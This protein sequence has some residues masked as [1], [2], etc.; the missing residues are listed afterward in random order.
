MMSMKSGWI[1]LYRKMMEHW[2]W[3]YREPYDRRSA[4]QY[5]LLEAYFCDSTVFHKGEIIHVERGQFPTSIRDLAEQWM[6]SKGKVQRFLNDLEAEHMIELN[7]TKNGTLLTVVNYGFYQGFEDSDVTLTE[8]VMSTSTGHQRYSDEYTNGTLA[9]HNIR[10]KE[11]KEDKEDKELKKENNNISCAFETND[12][13]GLEEF[14]NDIWKLYPIKK[15]KGQVS[16]TKKKVLQRK[17][18]DQIKRCVERFINDME[19]E[20]RDKKYWMHGSTFFNSGY[21]D[22]LDENYFPQKA[23]K[24]NNQTMLEATEEEE[25]LDGTEW[26]DWSKVTNDQNKA[27]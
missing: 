11:Y 17:G 14:F 2:I 1:K 27:I 24:S 3:K 26:T 15:G 25:I 12:D 23:T 20:G 8:T 10:N 7:R 21:V 19:G 16:K 5:I 4:W 13:D 6:W 22:Y 18:Y 9:G